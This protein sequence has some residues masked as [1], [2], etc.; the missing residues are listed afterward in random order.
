MTT[1][2]LNNET[3]ARFKAVTGR[4]ARTL[5]EATAYFE[6]SSNPRPLTGWEFAQAKRNARRFQR[7]SRVPRFGS[8]EWCETQGD[9]LGESGDR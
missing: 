1:E 7:E 9:N 4:N 2:Q 3:L 5:K 8:A 6:R